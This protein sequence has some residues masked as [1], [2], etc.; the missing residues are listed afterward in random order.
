VAGDFSGDGKPDVISNSEGKTRLFVVPDWREVILNEG[1][2]YDFIHSEFFDVDR[3]GD[4]LYQ[5]GWII[6][7]QQ[8]AKPLEQPWKL[9]VVDDQLNGI[10]GLL[11][12][13]VDGDGRLDLVANSG[14]PL[15][16]FPTADG[17]STGRGRLWRS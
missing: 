9:R 1:K 10:H 2:G 13:D 14:Q 16:P 6:W 15:K 7:L 8:P 5:P 17:R 12:G 3:D 11:K 4:P